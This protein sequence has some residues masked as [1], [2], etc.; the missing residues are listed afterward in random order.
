MG[1]VESKVACLLLGAALGDTLEDIQQQT[2]DLV[3]E[4]GAAS[5]APNGVQPTI[6]LRSLWEDYRDLLTVAE[7]DC[8]F[9]DSEVLASTRF[10]D[11]YLHRPSIN[12]PVQLTQAQVE[13]VRRALDHITARMSY[14]ENEGG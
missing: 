9:T 2:E 14:R 7:M 12:E 5:S 10:I 3:E 6:T 11:G 1:D 13:E 8:S 4:A